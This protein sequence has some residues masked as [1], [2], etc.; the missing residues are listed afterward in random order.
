M[1]KLDTGIICTVQKDK[2]AT[3]KPDSSCVTSV[4]L[5]QIQIILYYCNHAEYGI[6]LEY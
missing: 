3:S 2:S 4:T 5:D 1:R 6:F